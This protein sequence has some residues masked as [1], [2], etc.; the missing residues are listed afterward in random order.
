MEDI[1]KHTFVPKHTKLS[2]DEIAELLKKYNISIKQLPKISSKD[3]VIKDIETKT[4]DVFK[5]IRDSS[6]NKEAF[7]YRVVMHE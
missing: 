7:F 2:D 4:G 3:P 1:T 5:I 6:T